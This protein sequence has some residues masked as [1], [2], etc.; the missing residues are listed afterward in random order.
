VTD[1]VMLQR[2][3]PSEQVTMEDA[4]I[5]RNDRHASPSDRSDAQQKIPTWVETAEIR[6][7][8]GGEAMT[9]NRYFVENPH[10]VMG[11]HER[12][13]TMRQ[14]GELTVKL[15]EGGDLARM[16]GEAIDQLPSKVIDLDKEAIDKSLERHKTM[17]ESLEVALAGHE[18]GHVEMYE[19]KLRN[20][21]ERETPT[22]GIELARRD[23]TP[24]TP[25]SPQLSMD[26]KGRWFT[27]EA[28][29]DDNGKKVKQGR[30]NVYDKK[31]YPG[32]KV[33]ASLQLGDARYDR[34]REIVNLRDLL[35]RQLILEA[36]DAPAREMESNRGR[37]A[38]A[39]DRY[40]AKHGLL[41]DPKNN[42]LV[43]QMPDGSLVQALEFGYRPG[44]T[45][46]R[47]AKTGGSPMRRWPIGRRSCPIASCRSTRNRKRP[48]ARTMPCRSP[49]RSSDAS[50]SSASQACSTQPQM[51]RP[52]CSRTAIRR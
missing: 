19:G 25:W 44:V 2:L 3:A 29:T 1:I 47:A 21:Y 42:A 45:A 26:D 50:T 46:A 52:A 9:V 32:N 17:S 5:A 11:R 16:L 8:L 48:T 36:N 27:L 51:M 30:G 43:S 14:R 28:R 31:F 7:P 40:V 37:L 39:Y 38:G 22:G 12:S 10:M 35:K 49:C 13:G 24:Q 20:V 41:N 23:L 18:P 6:D 33:P 15:P 34:L 4:F